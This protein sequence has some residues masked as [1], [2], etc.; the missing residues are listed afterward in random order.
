MPRL[1][2]SFRYNVEASLKGNNSKFKVLRT[3]KK[4]L[5]GAITALALLV[6]TLFAMLCGGKFK[7][8][9]YSAFMFS[10]SL[11]LLMGGLILK[12]NKSI[13]SHLI[14]D[15]SAHIAI[16]NRVIKRK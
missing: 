7:N 11:E 15:A 1:E 8:V 9:K 3:C 4:G 10:R 16:Y 2:L 13:G 6:F 5:V 12:L 14:M